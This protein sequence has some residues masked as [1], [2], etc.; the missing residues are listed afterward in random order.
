MTAQAVKASGQRRQHCNDKT[1]DQQLSQVHQEPRLE[2]DAKKAKVGDGP[3]FP[4]QDALQTEL[5]IRTVSGSFLFKMLVNGSTLG[6]EVINEVERRDFIKN[7]TFVQRLTVGDDIVLSNDALAGSIA[8]AAA[9]F[10]HANIEATVVF[11]AV[12]KLHLFRPCDASSLAARHGNWCGMECADGDT[13]EEQSSADEPNEFPIVDKSVQHQ[14]IDDAPDDARAIAMEMLE[15]CPLMDSTTILEGEHKDAK[16][17]IIVIANPG[18]NLTQACV[19]AL[20]II[21]SVSG[22]ATSYHRDWGNYLDRGF[23]VPASMA[24]EIDANDALLHVTKIMNDKLTR[25][26]E[27]NLAYGAISFPVIFGGYASDGSIVGVLS[28]SQC[29][30]GR[31]GNWWIPNRFLRT[32]ESRH[33]IC[34]P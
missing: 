28:W 23:H 3:K 6:A 4:D 31:A 27:F 22:Q 16:G 13:S 25:H 7:G 10:A 19:M 8:R 9:A 21:A 32:W 24:D 17:E 11:S 12:P 14:C 18:D 1:G 15:A 33:L 2:P 5:T 30:P 29:E 34:A 26:F 20:G